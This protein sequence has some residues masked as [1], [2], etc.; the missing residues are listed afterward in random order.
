MMHCS[1]G[2]ACVWLHMGGCTACARQGNPLGVGTEPTPA[3][4]LCQ[5]PGQCAK[6]CERQECLVRDIGLR[7]WP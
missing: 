3:Q 4:F 5:R 2:R 1:D 6:W 7:S